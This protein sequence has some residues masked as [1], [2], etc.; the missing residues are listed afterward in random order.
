MSYC[1]EV[2]GIGIYLG[3]GP[4]PGNVIRN[5]VENAHCII[6]P[7]IS[8]DKLFCTSESYTII[9]LPI[10]ATIND[11]NVSPALGASLSF[12]GN[13]CTVTRIG[14]FNDEI[15][16]TASIT[17]P[18]G[19]MVLTR[20]LW[21]GIPRIEFVTIKNSV[22]D[23]PY[24]CTSHYDNEF[25]FNTRGYADTFDMFE[26]QLLSYPSMTLLHA[27]NY[28]GGEGVWDYL[29]APGWYIFRARIVDHACGTPSAWGEYE[30]EFV[31][32]S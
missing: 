21:I 12:S 32:C 17:T 8:G 6:R 20:K 16:L 13:N 2:T 22:N 14:N 5:F 18:C 25:K 29:P 3:F 9:N 27:Q 26:V 1:I 11:W 30:V 4:Q 28:Y 24:F 31:N 19:D 23:D 15:I 7:T 10:G